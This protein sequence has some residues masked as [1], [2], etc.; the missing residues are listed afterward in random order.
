VTAEAAELDP[1]RSIDS[2]EALV[3]NGIVAEVVNTTNGQQHV[4][5]YRYIHE[6][7]RRAIYEQ[8][9]Q[10]RRRWLH[11]RLA[12]AI[13]RRRAGDL[14]RYS[15]ILAHHRAIGAEPDGD[16]RA[17][18]W[19]WRAAAHAIG[20]GA[21]EEAV[22]LHRQAL[23]HVPAADRKLRAE[24][25][26]NL[27]LAQLAAGHPECDQTILNGAIEALH[28][29]RLN[30]AAQAAL[31]LADTV[32]SHPRLRR[33]ATALIDLLVQKSHSGRHTG[34]DAPSS[35]DDVT[36]GLLLARQC[37]LGI[38]VA[39]GTAA[40]TA[41]NA[42]A[43]E[44]RLLEGP[45]HVKRRLTL[46]EEMLIVATATN[47]R[48]AQI[49][50][51]HHRAMAAE[52]TGDLTARQEAL[53]ALMSAVGDGNGELLGDALLVDH[54][55]AA[56]VTQGRLTDAVAAS[57]L[58]IPAI[59]D[60]AHGIVPAP[61]S[62]AVR[63]ML[64][65]RWLRRST[66][67]T[68]AQLSRTAETAERSLTALIEGD[69]GWSHL[70]VRALATG[71]EPL[72]SGDEWPHSVGLLAL[73]CVELGD[74]TTADAVRTLLMPYADLTCGVGYRSFVGPMSF[75]L[76]RLAVI[77]GDWDEAERHLSSALPELASRQ[78]R[79]WMALA[80][81]A[82]ARALQARA[83][84]CDRRSA[85]TLQAEATQTLASLGLQQHSA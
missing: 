59:G 27:G 4:H 83:R 72:P 75:H 31:G 19:A 5:K 25:L 26:T 36:L 18:Q 76:G 63:Q 84:A 42:L 58:A 8:F 80:Q 48:N 12:D 51:A 11:T 68:N 3:A 21:P 32:N 1:V 10:A 44:L 15:R 22:Y 35:I 77:T 65:A 29:G 66:W 67:P 46:A 79:P 54:A 41:L 71:A 37:R 20:D 73:G 28:S 49:L 43:Q 16:Q 30:I 85:H 62:L 64:V 13:E 57:K 56:A 39:A 17:V 69:R 78:A 52:M 2:L 60:A 50:A 74:P 14:S 47:D 9:S 6:I 34:R 40:T 24:A 61:G 45:N 33:E 38:P 81:Q 70:A 55:V 82:L 53:A 7:L 23:D